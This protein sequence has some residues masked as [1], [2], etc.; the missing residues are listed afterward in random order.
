M[1]SVTRPDLGRP[2]DTA[3]AFP[4]PAVPPV[5][6]PWGRDGGAPVDQVPAQPST[7][8]ATAARVGWAVPAMLGVLGLA[9]IVY[10]WDLTISGYANTYYA[11]AAQA[12][13]QSWT[14]WLFGSLDAGNFITLDKPPFAT[15]VM[16]LSVRLFG[17]SSWSIL[18]PQA[19]AGVA[20]VGILMLTVRRGLGA[21]AAV[22]A[23]FVAALTPAAVLIFRFDNPDAMLT[24]LLVGA[25]YALTRAIASGAHRWVVLAGVLIGFAFLTKYLQAYLVLPAFALVYAVAAVGSIRRRIAG[26]AIAAL[27]VA[28]ASGW[29][30]ALMELLPA[31][32]RPY[33]GGS[34][35]DSVVALLLGYDG[36]GRI[37]G[38]GGPGGGGG[39]PGAGFSGVPGILRLFNA[40]FG[41]QIAWLLPLAFA[42]LGIGDWRVRWRLGALV[43]AAFALLVIPDAGPLAAVIVPS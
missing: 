39:G 23:G 19:L 5:T 3:P 30:V 17:L 21:A 8:A 11:M 43:V 35:T 1:T 36:L 14:A 31:T 12:A 2:F 10:L 4:A 7:V 18:L 38:G 37:F 42:G 33:I 6:S 28:I 22:I 13:S 15:M 16:G 9:A 41:G 27:S 24:L 25:A 34:G 20:T 32:V 29:W 26:L 40:E